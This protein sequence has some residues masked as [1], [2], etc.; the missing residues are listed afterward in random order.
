MGNKSVLNV[1]TGEVEVLPMT[2]AEEAQAAISLAADNAAIAAANHP[3]QLETDCTNYLNGGGGK[4]DAR[5]VLKA[6]FI[7]DLAFRLGVA[8]GALTAQQLLNERNRIAA[9]YKS[10]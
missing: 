5:K 2:P 10:L 6:K 9:I 7:S 4:I 8:P 1:T 3:D